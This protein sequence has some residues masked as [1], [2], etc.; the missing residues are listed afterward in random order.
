MYWYHSTSCNRPGRPPAWRFFRDIMNNVAITPRTTHILDGRTIRGLSTTRNHGMVFETRTYGPIVFELMP[1]KLKLNNKTIAIDG[2]VSWYSRIR[3]PEVV[4]DT[5]GDFTG[6][7]FQLAST[8]YRSR[9][10]YCDKGLVDL[11]EDFIIGNINNFARCINRVYIIDSGWGDTIRGVD[12]ETKRYIREVCELLNIPL[13]MESEHSTI[14]PEDV[15]K[16][17]HYQRKAA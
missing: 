14:T 7:Q 2:N 12:D 1:E 5:T 3:K 9:M 11:A 10:N 15:I 13:T 16:S 6:L 4:I 17:Y 8:K